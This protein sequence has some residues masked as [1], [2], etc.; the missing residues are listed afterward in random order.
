[1]RAWG[2]AVGLFGDL[3][4]ALLTLFRHLLPSVPFDSVSSG[5]GLAAVRREAFAVS[6]ALLLLRALFLG[7]AVAQAGGTPRR[8]G[9]CR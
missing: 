6:A 5:A 3:L 8:W 7:P 4:G 9:Q 1:M 2:K